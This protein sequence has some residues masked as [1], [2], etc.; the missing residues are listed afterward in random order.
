MILQKDLPIIKREIMDGTIL[1]GSDFHIPFQ[2]NKAVDA[3]IDYAIETQPEVIV[4]NGDLLDFYRLSKFTKAEGRNPRQEIAEAKIILE[5]LR[6]GCP[7]TDIYYPIGNHESRLE[8]YVF[9]KAPDLESIIDSFYDLLECKRFKVQ[10]C[11]RVVIN[12]EIVLKHG[13]FVAQK[14]GQ[15]AIKEMDSSYSSGATGHTHR[16]AKIIRRINGKKFYWLETGCLCDLQPHYKLQP[17]WTQGFGILKIKDYKLV[18]AD[19]KEI[20]DG[21]II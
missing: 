7:Y 8:T 10:G 17:D 15:T 5:S 2:D 18:Y 21:K 11:H 9:N 4:I 20:E 6:E 12:N 16:L 19:V 3:F 14:A 1:I 13:D